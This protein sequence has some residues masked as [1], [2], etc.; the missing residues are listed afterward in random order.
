MTRREEALLSH[1]E[2]VRGLRHSI[3]YLVSVMLYQLIRFVSIDVGT[4]V[5]LCRFMSI[6][7]KLY[8][9]PY[10][11]LGSQPSLADAPNSGPHFPPK[12]K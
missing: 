4:C 1:A 10:Y 2:Q 11:L 5:S 12:M 7:V 8:Q 6:Y 9:N 3:F